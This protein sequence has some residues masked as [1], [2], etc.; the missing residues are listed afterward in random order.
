MR[1]GKE[2]ASVAECQWEPST[3]LQGGVYCVSYSC[4]PVG[5]YRGCDTAGLMYLL[6]EPYTVHC[7]RAGQHLAVPWGALYRSPS[8]GWSSS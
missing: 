5:D 3:L 1:L 2:E 6:E 4:G 7:A 8:G